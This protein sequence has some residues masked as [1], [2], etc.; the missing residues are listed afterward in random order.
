[1]TKK[2]FIAGSG[3]IGE[4][5]ALLL[6]EWSANE[7]EIYL[8]DV[9]EENLRKAK[10]FVYKN[11]AKTSN[12]ATVLMPKEGIDD[13]MRAAFEACDVL[14]DCSPSGAVVLD[15][16]MG[17][18][19][20]IIAAEKVRRVAYG[21]EIDPQYVDVAVR[22]W[23]RYTGRDAVL[24]GSDETFDEVGERRSAEQLATPEEA[25]HPGKGSARRKANRV[26]AA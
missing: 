22:R 5:A 12:V 3:G 11:S 9:A 13:A 8:G 16:F 25:S 2:I 24:V 21:I 6:R 23:Q 17:S 7:T 26:E 4:A 1:M 19:T 14:L 18:G 20:T 10:D 15:P